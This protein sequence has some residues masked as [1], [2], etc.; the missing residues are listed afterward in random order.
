MQLRERISD[1]CGAPN[2][3]YNYRCVFPDPGIPSLK[4]RPRISYLVPKNNHKYLLF[5]YNAVLLMGM[6]EDRRTPQNTAER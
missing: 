2:C 5:V 6:P 4:S 1:R 3:T